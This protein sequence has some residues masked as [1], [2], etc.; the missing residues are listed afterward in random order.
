[1]NLEGGLLVSEIE[2]LD[3]NFW[4]MVHAV[5]TSDFNDLMKLGAQ[6]NYVFRRN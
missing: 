2:L 6:D 1:M 5:L 3:L 4:V